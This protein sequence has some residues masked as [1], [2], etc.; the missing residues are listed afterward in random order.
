MSAL[1]IAPLLALLAALPAQTPPEQQLDNGLR[2]VL[3]DRPELPLVTF[4]LY[5]RGGLLADGPSTFRHAS[6]AMGCMWMGCE[7]PTLGT[8]DEEAVR[9]ALADIGGESSSAVDLQDTRVQ[10]S[11]LAPHATRGLEL[12]TAAL[13]SPTYPDAVVARE[14]EQERNLLARRSKQPE[15]LAQRALLQALCGEHPLS[16]AFAL[17]DRHGALAKVNRV[18]LRAEHR[19]LVRPGLGTLFVVGPLTAAL[20]DAVQ[21]RFASWPDHGDAPPPEPPP[22]TPPA[23]H[24]VIEVPRPEMTQIYVQMATL[25]PAPSDPQF[26]TTPLFRM[27]L[28]GGYTSRMQDELRVN[29]GLVY[30]I[31][32]TQPSLS[33]AAPTSITTSTRP[34]KVVELLDVTAGILRQTLAGDLP[35]PM[36]E[37]ARNLWL[38]NRA[39]ERESHIGFTD[40]MHRGLR[41]FGALDGYA[42]EIEAVRTATVADVLAA[43]QRFAPEKFVVVLVGAP[44]ELAKFDWRWKG[45]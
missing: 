14:V 4:A 6:L 45:Q 11:C 31:T 29:R 26:A 34:D 9:S 33:I 19:R 17:D 8:L 35:A 18:A 7:S 5:L 42:R 38:A 13:L 25:G 15:F 41:L 22:I 27:A 24:R 39:I 32:F 40:A 23:G 36:L 12:L 3:V 28:S 2:V 43:G 37:A 20:R 10:L 21:Q 30:G 1:R 44:E 16:D